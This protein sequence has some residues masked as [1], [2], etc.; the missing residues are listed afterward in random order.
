[1]SRRSA[2]ARWRA[3][4]ATA[5]RK[6]AAGRA[7]RRARCR[8]P[9]CPRAPPE[10]APRSRRRRRAPRARG[11]RRQGAQAVDVQRRRLE[12]GKRANDPPGLVRKPELAVRFVE[13]KTRRF[14]KSGELSPL[15]GGRVAD[16]V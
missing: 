14:R 8:A 9:P 2:S 5:I 11:C 13:S 6:K 1:M 16:D 12:I 15:K 7:P 3:F 10:A 4:C